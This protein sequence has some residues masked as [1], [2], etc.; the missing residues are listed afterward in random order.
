MTEQEF[1]S[2]LTA[3]GFQNIVTVEREPDGF[4]DTHTHPFEAKALIV[5]GEIHIKAQDRDQT[6][7]TGQIFHL[8]AEVPHAERYGPAGVKYMVGRKQH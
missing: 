1:I 2:A 5:S 7:K 4:L 3:E 8:N 6:Y